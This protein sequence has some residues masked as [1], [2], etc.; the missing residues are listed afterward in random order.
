MDTHDWF[1]RPSVAA[2][3][4]A[5]LLG[6]ATWRGSLSRTPSMR[7]PSAILRSS[8]VVSVHFGI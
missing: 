4:N 1:E 7:E 8:V 2:L 6:T 5:L 3:V